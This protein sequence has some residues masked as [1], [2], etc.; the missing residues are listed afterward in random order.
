MSKKL[1]HK[2][3]LEKL[4]KDNKAFA[5]GEFKILS[6][7]NGY[8]NKMLIENKYGKC[9][10]TPTGLFSTDGFCN[11]RSAINKTEY[12]LNQVKEKR[13]DFENI[14]YS[15]TEYRGVGYYP[16][17]KCKVHD[18]EYTQKVTRHL[19]GKQGCPHCSKTIIR[20]SKENFIKHKE[21]FSD[22]IGILYVIL[23]FSRQERFYKVG[24]TGENRYEYRKTDLS[25]LYNIE[26]LYTQQGQIEEIYN[27]EQKFLN[28]FSNYKYTPEKYFQGYT[29]CLTINPV[30]EYYN[31]FQ[32]TYNG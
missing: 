23:M 28:E 4:S 9:E 17:F 8:K 18:Y 22:K 26:V 19:Y 25:R 12:W 2:E 7:Y 14:D 16:I 24:I 27:L 5:N 13:T 31:W 32:N 20:Y 30:E 10:I 11:V 15:K 3:F 21:F 6:K 29:E 1:T